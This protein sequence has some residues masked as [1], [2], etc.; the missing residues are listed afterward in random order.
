MTS[1]RDT[2]WRQS[3]PMGGRM[4]PGACLPNDGMSRTVAHEAVA[5]RLEAHH[6]IAKALKKLP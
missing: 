4:T 5:R 3:L 2:E 6:L 1:V